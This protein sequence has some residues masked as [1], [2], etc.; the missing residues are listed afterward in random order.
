MDG[1]TDS[2]PKHY[3]FRWTRP[4]LLNTLNL[5]D[6]VTLGGACDGGGA[7]PQGPQVT[8]FVAMGGRLAAAA[9]A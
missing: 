5:S 6:A 8:R 9:A 3:A 4:A 1:R 7:S 2:S